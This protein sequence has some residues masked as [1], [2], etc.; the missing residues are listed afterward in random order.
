MHRMTDKQK[1]VAATQ[2]LRPYT[3]WSARCAMNAPAW[4]PGFVRT[5]PLKTVN[6]ILR[7][8]HRALRD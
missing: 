5:L 4:V 1:L 7:A 8:Y 2:W 6:L 3:R